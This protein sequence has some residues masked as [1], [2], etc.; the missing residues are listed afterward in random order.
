MASRSASEAALQVVASLIRRQEL[1]GHVSVTVGLN[2]VAALEDRPGDGGFGLHLLA[3]EE[4]RGPRTGGIERV[5][6]RRRVVLVWAV[7]EG[8]R[9]PLG[10]VR[11]LP[12]REEPPA[13]ERVDL[14]AEVRHQPASSPTAASASSRAR[15][16]RLQTSFPWRSFQRS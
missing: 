9:D 12:P 16:V 11:A 3:D 1:V 2:V 10:P 13:F 14:L 8:Q 5:E 15:K 7:V 4:E 6:H